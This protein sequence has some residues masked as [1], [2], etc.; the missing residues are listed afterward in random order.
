[1]IANQKVSGKRWAVGRSQRM[2]QHS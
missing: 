1:M 2:F